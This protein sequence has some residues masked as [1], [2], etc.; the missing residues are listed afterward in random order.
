MTTV[1]WDNQFSNDDGTVPSPSSAKR[2]ALS[3]SVAKSD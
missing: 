2:A 1:G 3:E